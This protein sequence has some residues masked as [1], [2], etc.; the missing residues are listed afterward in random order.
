[1]KMTTI[2]KS[3]I[4]AVCIALGVVLPQAFHAIPNAG[5]IYC[6]M[7]IPVLI[8]GLICGWQYGLLAGLVTP[9]LSSVFTGMPPAAYLPPMMIELAIYGCV[10][11]LMMK[12]VKTKNVYADLYISLIVAMLTGRIIAGAARALIFASGKYSLAVWGTSYFVTA[13]PG[14]IIQMVLIPS[15]IFALM[16]ANLI[17]FRYPKVKQTT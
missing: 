6:P 8:C 16:K 11:G 9:F 2:K 3:I 13:L 10:C 15:I 1:M 4:T 17:P 12:F 5:S 14:I 7:H